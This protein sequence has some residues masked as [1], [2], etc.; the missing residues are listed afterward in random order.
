MKLIT[1]TNTVVRYALT[2]ATTVTVEAGRVVTPDF[3][4]GDMNNSNCTVHENVTVPGDFEVGKYSYDGST[5]TL[6]D[7]WVAP[8]FPANPVRGA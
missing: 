7:G 8:S 3:I 5:F 4:I 6:T 1:S 2:D